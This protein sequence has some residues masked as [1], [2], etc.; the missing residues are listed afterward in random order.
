MKKSYRLKARSN[1]HYVDLN[2]DY[3]QE[4]F[5]TAKRDGENWIHFFDNKGKEIFAAE[6]SAAGPWSRLFRI[7]MRNLSDKTKVLLLYFYEGVTKYLEF[8]GTSRV[9][10]VTIDNNDLKSLAIY[11]GPILWDEVRGF[12]NHY[13]QRK[14]EIS[15]FDLDKDSIREISVKYGRMS[16]IY[17]YL[18]KGEW[19]NFDDK[20]VLLKL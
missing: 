15:L 6:I 14:Y 11:K 3:R 2:G 1:R 8:Q 19:F 9:Y 17:K 4:S 16:R 7:Q 10:F 12:K 13:H 20:K 5:Y 18:G